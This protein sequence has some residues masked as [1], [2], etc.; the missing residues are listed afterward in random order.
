MV[1][2]H[3]LEKRYGDRVAVRNITFT[4][5][6][7]EIL[8]FLGPNGAG[9]TTTMRM[10]TGF[11]PP[12][13]GTVTVAGFDLFKNPMEIRRRLGYLPE[14]PPLYLEMTVSEYLKFAGKIKGLS[15]DRLRS[16]FDMVIEKCRLGEV[17]GRLIANL[18][19]GFRQRV[20]LAQA[21]IHNPEVLILDEPTNGLDPKQIIE[22]REL[23][24]SL[25]GERTVILSTHILPEATAVCQKVVIINKGMIV[26]VDSPERLSSQFR[27]SERLSFTIREVDTF[28]PQ[29]IL[30]LS[31]VTHLT[32]DTLH[33]GAYI[34][35]TELGRDV[36]SDLARTIIEN[37]WNLLEL[38]SLTVS[39]EEVFLHLTTEEQAAGLEEVS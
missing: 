38:K 28:H 5:E 20:G 35:E 11:I 27:Q 1:H 4:V 12:T 22:I 29:K 16:G 33:E 32:K 18:S 9:K 13:Q 19:K 10:I 31:G 15:G 2:V 25:R 17:A 3:E 34:V 26:A 24:H 7:G 14:N 39:L 30:A 36:R 6:K 21:L 23:I 37:G 8:A